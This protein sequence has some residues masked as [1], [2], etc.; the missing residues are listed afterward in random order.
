MS[1]DDGSTT[2]VKCQAKAHDSESY[3]IPEGSNYNSTKPDNGGTLIHQEESPEP[4]LSSTIATVYTEEEEEVMAGEEQG[5]GA[6]GGRGEDVVF[7]EEVKVGEEEME[8]RRDTREEDKEGSKDRLG[9]R[10]AGTDRCYKE[11]KLRWCNPG[12]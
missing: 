9:H 10:L 11:V 2:K 1:D 12:L 8:R 4:V 5:E 7:L 3:K 6:E